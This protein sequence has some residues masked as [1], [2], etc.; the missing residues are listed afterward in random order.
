LFRTYLL[1]VFAGWVAF[2]SNASGAAEDAAVQHRSLPYEQRAEVQ[3]Y[4]A[5]LVDE[6]NFTKSELEALLAQAERK[7]SILDAIS[8]PAERTLEWKDYRK[9]FMKQDRIDGGVAFWNANVEALARAEE[10]YGVGAEYIAAIIGVETRYGKFMGKYRVLDA[11]ATLGFDYPPRSKFFRRELTEYLL[12]TREE[13]MDPLDQL[14]SYAGAMGYGQFISS[15]FRAYAVDFDGDGVR[16]ILRNKTDA[17]GSV[18]NYFKRHGWKGD[19][20]IIVPVAL[21]DPAAAA[22]ANKGEALRHTVASLR[23]Q[24]VVIPCVDDAA[25][26]ALFRMEADAGTQ[27]WVGLNDFY[28]ITRYN[29]S[30]MY[31]LA[32]HQLAQAIK[33]ARAL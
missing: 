23:S 31:A 28:A 30:S 21:Q 25:K 16:D 2:C 1:A 17:I 12:M 4:I 18:A 26:A 3:A 20:Q 24:G 10:K 8:K 27:Y 33:A 5:A 22:L 29:H 19:A 13:G 14:G 9:I 11:L 32:V 6:H 15:S 7:Q